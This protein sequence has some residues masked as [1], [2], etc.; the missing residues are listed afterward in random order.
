MCAIDG[1]PAREARLANP[2][3][4]GRT[5]RKVDGRR[6]NER[7]LVALALDDSSGWLMHRENQSDPKS[8]GYTSTSNGHSWNN[9]MVFGYFILV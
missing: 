3:G 8:D 4:E 7:R 5:C 6:K 9:A 1:F 2:I